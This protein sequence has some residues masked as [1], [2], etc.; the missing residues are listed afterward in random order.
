MELT[1][2][3]DNP[4]LGRREVHFEI[5][6]PSTPRRSKVR[7]EIAVQMKAELNQVYIKKL[8]TKTGTQTTVGLAH[9]YNEPG[10][11]LE[12]EPEHIIE[13]NK[14]KEMEQEDGQ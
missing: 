7:R 13:R 3:R 6:E 5:R 8:E 10:K 11:A 1:S 2:T 4:L 9:V 14:A 12:I